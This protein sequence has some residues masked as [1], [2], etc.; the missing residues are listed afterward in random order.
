M[1][2]E[3]LCENL[4]LWN[5]PEAAERIEALRADLKST[6]IRIE[7]I[8][9]VCRGLAEQLMKAHTEIAQALGKAGGE[10]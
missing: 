2:D 5:C 1:T 7:I 6:S 4:R 3:E 8:Q 9:T 10:G